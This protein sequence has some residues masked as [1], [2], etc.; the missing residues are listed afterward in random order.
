MATRASRRHRGRHMAS[1]PTV[2]LDERTTPGLPVH[3]SRAGRAL[4]VATVPWQIRPPRDSRTIVVKGTCDIVPGGAARLRSEAELVSGDVHTDDRQLCLRYASDFAVHKPRADVTLV[5]TARSPSPTAAMRVSF[6][7]G[8]HGRFFDRTIAVI[9]DRRWVNGALGRRATTPVPFTEMPLSYERAFGGPA[10]A[11]NPVGV[12]AGPGD[13]GLRLPNLEEFDA[14]VRAPSDAP[15]PACFAPIAPS[16]AARRAHLGTYDARWLRARW[17][18]WPDDLD[19]QHEQSAPRAQQLPH[20]E[21]DEPFEL[22]GVHLDHPVLHGWLPGVRPRCIAV[23]APRRGGGILD[24][25]LRL[26]TVAFD[27]DAMKIDLVWRAVLEVEDDE[28]SELVALLVHADALAEPPADAESIYAAFATALTPVPAD[29]PVRPAAPVNDVEPPDEELAEV[30]RQLNEAERT[31]IERLTAAGLWPPSAATTPSR[32]ELA[33]ALAAS[34]MGDDPARAVL[35]ELAAPEA[36][37]AIEHDRALRVRAAIARGEPLDGLD[38]SGLDLSGIDLS[39]RSLV[40][41]DLRRAVLAR[42]RLAGADLTEAVLEGALAREAVFDGASLREADLHGAD[43]RSASLREASLEGAVLSSV[44]ADGADFAGS[45]GARVDLS[46]ARLARARFDD[47]DLPSAD[48]SRATLDE[49]SFARA[50]LSEV[51][52]YDAV[53]PSARFDGADLTD[54][55]ADAA[56]LPSASL[57]HARAPGSVWEGADLSGVDAYGASLAGASFARARCGDVIFSAA[58][59][60]RASFRRAFLEGASLLKANLMQA[61]FERARMRRADLRGANLHGAELLRAA[62]EEAR[63]ELAI[64]TASKLAGTR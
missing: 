22:V 27:T 23:R 30:E 47:A 48:L 52:L 35:D 61:S 33:A 16:W 10:H 26:D 60:A 31:T 37:P 29:A 14:L 46:D 12:G 5:G 4:S 20:V 32:D 36:P 45:R 40:R 44:H 8:D 59:L 43:L 25:P 13:I 28:A 7:F 63:T 50:R 57:R 54:A 3:R 41:T 42:A 18:Y 9:G 38:L 62:L 17:P 34:G 11:A 15:P 1:P 56:S 49:A 64:V 21:G 6:R 19:Y 39:G 53:G 2:A 55:R 51:R 24:V 58:D